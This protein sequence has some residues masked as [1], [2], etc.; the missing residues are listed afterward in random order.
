MSPIDAWLATPLPGWGLARCLRA[1]YRGA[2]Y[3]V[4][5]VERTLYARTVATGEGATLL[6]A[7]DAAL[8]DLSAREAS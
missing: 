1:E 4:Q 8:A 7:C 2:Y 6:A 5:L 3:R